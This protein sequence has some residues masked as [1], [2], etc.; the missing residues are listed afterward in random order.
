METIKNRFIIENQES[1]G[2]FLFLDEQLEPSFTKNIEEAS[3]YGSHSVSESII[4]R[5]ED[6]GYML[7]LEIK[8]L[9][10]TYKY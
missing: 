10:I 8:E 3:H 1:K 6:I 2:F 9:E 4:D 5:L 7:K